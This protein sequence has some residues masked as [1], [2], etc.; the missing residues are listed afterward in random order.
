MKSFTRS[1]TRLSR[2]TFA[3]ALVTAWMLLVGARAVSARSEAP[4]DIDYPVY[5]PAPESQSAQ[6]ADAKSRGCVS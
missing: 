2:A 5:P 1:P 6:E 3:L 4:R